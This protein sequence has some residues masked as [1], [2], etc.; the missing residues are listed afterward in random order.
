[1]EQ[2]KAFLKL[3][4][5]PAIALLVAVLSPDE[6]IAKMASIT[7]IFT[8][9]PLIVEPLKQALGTSGWGT[10]ILS[11]VVSF[12]VTLSSW[13]FGF[14]FEGFE[15]WY[16]LVVSGGVTISAWGWITIEQFKLLLAILVGNTAKIAEIRNRLK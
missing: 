13:W 8:L 10:R 7:G 3:L 4:I 9:V 12:L 16:A 1:M 14:G 11:L 2:F 5:A 15:I 6:V